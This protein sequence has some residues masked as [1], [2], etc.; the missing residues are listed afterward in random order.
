MIERRDKGESVRVRTLYGCI[1][2]ILIVVTAAQAGAQEDVDVK[3]L[4]DYAAS[5]GADSGYDDQT[6]V[7]EKIKPEKFGFGGSYEENLG[8]KAFLRDSAIMYTGLWTSRFFYVRNK[9]SRIFDTSL[10]K[11]WHNITQWPVWDDG[12]S[13]FTNWVTHPTIGATEYL[14][15]RAMGHSVLVSALGVVVQSTLFEYTIE[16]TVEV[17]SLVDLVSTPLVGTA[18]GIV[19]EESSYWLVSTDFVPA[20]I[21]AHILNPMRNFVYDRQVGL[22]NPFTKTFMS[23]S[24]PIVFTPN[25]SIAIDLAYP[26]FLEEPL[27]MGRFKADLEIVNLKKEEGGQFVFYSLRADVPSKSGLWGVYVKIAQSGVNSVV[28]NGETVRDGFEF[29]NVLAGGKFLLWKSHN[30][31]VSGGVELILPTSYKDNIDRLSTVTMF[32]RNFPINLQ[33]AWTV[34]P[35]VTAAAW[36]G[37][38]NVQAMVS[39]DTVL[40]AD[41]LE[42]NGAEF[43]VN[44]GAAAGANFPVIASPVLYA[45]F[46]AYECLTADT[47]EKNDMFVTSGIRFGRKYSPGFALQFPVAGVDRGI[48]RYSYMFDFQVRF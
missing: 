3:D 25:K 12:D 48:D 20:K 30:S 24:G 19:L 31:A 27:P 15:Y 7:E 14:F 22:Y 33:K 38:F 34:T 18:L 13:F 9:N 43:S 4:L 35:Y 36:H 8:F 17:P 1:F 28:I 42:G 44:Y 46:N 47:F 26:Y 41:E 37:I 6:G 23:V 40:N 45:E 10:S 29:A 5:G 11:W 2:I 32:R 16:G 39:A 21:L